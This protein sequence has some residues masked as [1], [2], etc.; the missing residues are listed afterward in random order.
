MHESSSPLPPVGHFQ[1][2]IY[3]SKLSQSLYY[4]TALTIM[5]KFRDNEKKTIIKGRAFWILFLRNL[6]RVIFVLDFTFAVL[7]LSYVNSYS[8]S[9]WLPKVNQVIG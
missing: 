5:Q 2:F 8:N 4:F 1:F 3:I 7:F 6:S 9:K